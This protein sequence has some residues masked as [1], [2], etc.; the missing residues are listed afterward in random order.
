MGYDGLAENMLMLINKPESLLTPLLA[1]TTQ[2]LKKS[3]EHSKNQ[4]EWIVSI[5]PQVYKRIQITVC[6]LKCIYNI[7]I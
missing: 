1:I 7:K 5:P 2:R 4:P 3:L 6:I